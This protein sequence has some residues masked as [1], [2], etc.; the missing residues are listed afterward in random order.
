MTGLYATF[1]L[2]FMGTLHCVSAVLGF[3]SVFIII[4]LIIGIWCGVC[5]L[6]EIIVKG[7][8]DDTSNK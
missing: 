3:V 2:I 6:I 5:V 4:F 7:I 8:K 1:V